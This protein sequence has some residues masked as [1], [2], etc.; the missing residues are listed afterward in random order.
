MNDLQITYKD[1]LQWYGEAM[2]HETGEEISLFACSFAY[3]KIVHDSS[4]NTTKVTMYDFRVMHEPGTDEVTIVN[5]G[6]N[7]LL[8]DMKSWAETGYTLK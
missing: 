8:H 5:Y 2:L 7:W 1:I 6:S 3:Y 4:V